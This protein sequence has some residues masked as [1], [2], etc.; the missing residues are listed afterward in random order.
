V[1]LDAAAAIPFALASSRRMSPSSLLC[2]SA[3]EVN[4]HGQARPRSA[5][6]SGCSLHEFTHLPP[7]LL[8]PFA[9]RSRPAPAAA[10]ASPAPFWCARCSLPR[11][12]SRA[13]WRSRRAPSHMSLGLNGHTRRAEA[14]ATCG[15]RLSR[16]AK[17]LV[18]HA[19]RPR[20]FS[21]RGARATASG[22]GGE[23]AMVFAGLWE[24]TR[25]Q[26]GDTYAHG[27]PRA[28]HAAQ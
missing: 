22:S 11:P 4:A 3:A 10:A 15:Q 5:A 9:R 16:P 12:A 14:E 18:N 6:S 1:F 7:P 13:T 28:P 19:R 8:R 27:R 21:R 23:G 2:S 24:R 20:V 17:A 26:R 25:E